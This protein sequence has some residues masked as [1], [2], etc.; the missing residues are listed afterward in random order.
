MF[1][2]IF[3]VAAL[4]AAGLALVDR[5]AAAAPQPDSIG[6]DVSW[7]QCGKPLPAGPVFAVVGVSGGKPYTDNACLAT[8]YAWASASASPGGAAFYMNTSNP[9]RA[10]TALDWYAQRQPNATCGRQAEVACAYNFGFGAARHA[11]AYAERST[12]SAAGH[13]WW[14]DV[15]TDNSWSPADKAANVAAIRGSIDYL[16]GQGVPV[17]V[18]SA[19]RQWATITGS[20]S[21][22]EMA[23]WVA[24]ARTADEARTFCSRPSFTGGPVTMV[25]FVEGGFD[26][27]YVCAVTQP[28]VPNPS[29]LDGLVSLLGQLLPGS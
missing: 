26:R 18:Y 10:S 25:Q 28:V 17:G 3:A 27:N 13:P 29:L 6:Y 5:P 21:F 16:R 12:G 1:L 8:Q 19:G 24:G 22:P 9:G 14:L 15:E 2:R 23:N 4:A 11:F 7:P 20:A